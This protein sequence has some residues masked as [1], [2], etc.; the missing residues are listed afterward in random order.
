V[1]LVVAISLAIFPS[2]LPVVAKPLAMRD[3]I[4]GMVGELAIGATIG[5]GLQLVI[6]ATQLAGSVVAMQAGMSF[7]QSVDPMSDTS[8]SDL[9]QVFYVVASLTFLGIGGHIETMRTLLDSFRLAPAMR[10]SVGEPVAAFLVGQLSACF[11][12][13]LQL[14]AP[15]II[16]LLLSAL[17]LGFISRTVPQLHILNVGLPLKIVVAVFVVMSTSRW[18]RKASR[19]CSSRPLIR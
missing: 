17:T 14:A 16:A 11:A 13:A 9:G 3:A 4:A 8:T 5:L 15:G 12:L 18:P 1:F 2:V 6:L 19:S 10:F 7:A